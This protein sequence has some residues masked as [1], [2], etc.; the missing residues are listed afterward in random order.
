MLFIIM[1]LFYN[2][3]ITTQSGITLGDI[4]KFSESEY[5]GE[6][7]FIQWIFPSDEVSTINSL[8]PTIKDADIKAFAMSC[9]LRLK[10]NRSFV[11]FLDFLGLKLRDNEV[12]VSDMGKY[13][14]RVLRPNHNWQRITRVLR[15]LCLLGLKDKARA[16]FIFLEQTHT[17]HGINPITFDYWKKALQLLAQAPEAP[18][19][20]EMTLQKF[21]DQHLKL[22]RQAFN[23]SAYGC[24]ICVIPVPENTPPLILTKIPEME[25]IVSEYYSQTLDSKRE[26]D[27][28]FFPR[29]SMSM[30]QLL[31]K[32]KYK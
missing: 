16:F 7:D 24:L 19:V 28:T 30:I 3:Q 12:Y 26:V 5:E 32:P 31:I 14:L 25:K 17:Q 6:H 23:G 13:Y 29:E 8:A 27:V 10:L 1:A 15:C 2:Q 4:W 21:V 9:K 22:P 11:Q 18:E 20:P